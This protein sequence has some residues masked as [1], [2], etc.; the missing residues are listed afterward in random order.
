MSILD[1][2]SALC[3]LGCRRNSG[4]HSKTV[5]I[6]TFCKCDALIEA[7]KSLILWDLT[8][9]RRG[10]VRHLIR[11]T[12]NTKAWRDSIHLAKSLN[13]FL[14]NQS[15]CRMGVAGTGVYLSLLQLIIYRYY[16][17]WESISNNSR[18][19]NL[20]VI[21]SLSIH[22]FQMLPGNALWESLAPIA[23]FEAKL[24]K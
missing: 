21:A 1:S 10:R 8:S 2:S 14:V 5:T 18:L 22:R 19:Q 4:F 13:Y 12:D 23:T 11:A 20:S 3:S 17:L 9:G 7:V 6:R 16:S 15:R 24:P